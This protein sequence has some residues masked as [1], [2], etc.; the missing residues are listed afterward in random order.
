[1]YNLLEMFYEVKLIQN[2]IERIIAQNAINIAATD[3][4]TVTISIQLAGTINLK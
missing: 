2:W 4:H 1:M 3:Q